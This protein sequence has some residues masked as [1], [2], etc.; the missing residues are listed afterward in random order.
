LT[1]VACTVT[2]EAVIA[3][4]AVAFFAVVLVAV[5]L[6]ARRD[7]RRDRGIRDSLDASRAKPGEAVD[8]LRRRW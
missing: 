3:G 5:E 6:M 2:A 8:R 4:A 7:R 1:S